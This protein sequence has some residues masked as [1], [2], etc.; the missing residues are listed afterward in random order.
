MNIVISGATG[1]IGEQLV[2]RFCSDTLYNVIALGRNHEKLIALEQKVKQ[3]Y[4]DSRL[5]THCHNFFNFNEEEN[6]QIFD[7]YDSI[8][9]LINNAGMMLNKAFSEISADEWKEVY[10]VNLIS[11]ALLIK[12]LISKMGKQQK[13]HIVNISSMGGYQGSVKF[14]GLSAYASSK[15]A[16]TNLTELLATEFVEKNIAVNCLALGAVDTQMLKEAFP[17]YQAPLNAEEMADFIYWFAMNGQN[18]FNGKILPVA[19]STP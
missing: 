17:G 5:F 13:S 2:F 18:F 4:P 14:P 11:P 19:L 8:N 15:A 10:Q 1:G 6:A 9:V 7:A 12:S 16:L 3:K